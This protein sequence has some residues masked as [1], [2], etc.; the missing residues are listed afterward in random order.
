MW[1][2]HGN[3]IGFVTVAEAK[4]VGYRDIMSRADKWALRGESYLELDRSVHR[5]MRTVIDS[6][7]CR[8]DPTRQPAVNC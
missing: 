8:F 4:R 1:D 6:T 5:P 3:W 2:G 7:D